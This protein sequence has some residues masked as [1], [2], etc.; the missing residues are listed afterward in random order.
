MQMKRRGVEMRLV[1]GNSSPARIDTTLINGIIKARG[2][3]DELVSGR[4]GTLTQI[5]SRDGI[6]LGTLS[7]MLNLAFLAPDIIE[8]IMAGHHP[9]DLTVEKL[10]KKIELPL[11]WAEQKRLLGCA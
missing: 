9:A 2:W 10:T 3:F 7:R 1:I 5:A 6:D 11:D 8:A 4:V